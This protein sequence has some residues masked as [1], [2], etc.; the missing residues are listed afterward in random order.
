MLIFAGVRRGARWVRRR[1]AAGSATRGRVAEGGGVVI[2][3]EAPS[4]WHH[5]HH[6]RPGHHHHDRPEADEDVPNYGRATAFLVGMVH[7]IGAETPTQL[8][9]F[10]TAAGAGGP[11]VGVLVL[12]TFIVGLV[13]SNSVITVGSS[14]GF[15]QASRHFGLYAAVA[16]VTAVF[17]LAI[18]VLFVLG[19]EGVLP[20]FFGG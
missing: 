9:I 8:L 18:G 7:G 6:G 3:E 13:L 15:L 14:L 17:S 19:Q 4:L 10:L 12:A 16:V 5:G 1:V 20:A 2:V 11:L